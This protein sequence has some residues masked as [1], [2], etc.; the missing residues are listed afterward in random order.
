MV[1]F[2]LGGGSQQKAELFGVFSKR[3]LFSQNLE[4]RAAEIGLLNFAPASSKVGAYDFSFAFESSPEIYVNI[5]S[6]VAG[7]RT[8]KDDISK[9]RSF[10]DFFDSNQSC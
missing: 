7:G 10:F 2:H 3:L 1:I 8:N 9:A 6:S 5:K 4:K